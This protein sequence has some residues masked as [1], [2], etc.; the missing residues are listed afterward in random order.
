[1]MTGAA[2][3][4]G[5]LMRP[6]LLPCCSVNQSAPSGPAVIPSGKLFVVGKGYSVI[7]PCVVIRPIL[8]ALGSVNHNAPSC[9]AVIA[10]SPQQLGTGNSA[11]APAVVMRPI[12]FPFCSV[13]QSAPSRPA[14][15]PNGLAPA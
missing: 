5:K 11:I 12:L 15:I 6:T 10:C 1:M 4:A 8:F 2:F 7:A 9:A 3:P 13:N 14:T